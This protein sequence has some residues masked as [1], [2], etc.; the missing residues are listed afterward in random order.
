[1][2]GSIAR[3]HKPE[4]GELQKSLAK[5][6]NGGERGLILTRLAEIWDRIDPIDGENV[7]HSEG[8]VADLQRFFAICAERG[9]GL[10]G[11]W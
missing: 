10:K 4:S 2:R 11:W 7:G 9:L 5:R 1:L 6:V 8:E 3:S